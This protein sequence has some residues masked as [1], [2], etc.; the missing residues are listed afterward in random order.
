MDGGMVTLAE[1]VG[2][3]EGFGMLVGEFALEV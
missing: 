2:K 1:V 3:D